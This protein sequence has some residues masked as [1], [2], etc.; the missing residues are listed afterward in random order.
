MNYICD[1]QNEKEL[2]KYLHKN[3]FLI[4]I[5]RIVKN[6]KLKAIILKVI[7]KFYSN[8]IIYYKDEENLLNY[9]IKV[10]LMFLIYNRKNFSRLLKIIERE[11][12][13]NVVLSKNLKEDVELVNELK[14]RK[15]SI[16]DGRILYEALIKN[17][18]EY[19]FKIK[20]NRIQESEITFLITKNTIER[21]NIIDYFAQ[22]FK[23]TNIVTDNKL[24]F[25]ELKNNLRVRYGIILNVSENLNFGVKNADMVV[26]M[27]YE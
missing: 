6:R 13:K 1:I 4:L 7:Y 19:I 3:K 11:N 9:G 12:M 15:I 8:K 26:N 21:Q 5:E 25:E 24:K 22:K 2:Y 27:R 17:M 10:N 20:G 18:I 14:N 23:I 16:I